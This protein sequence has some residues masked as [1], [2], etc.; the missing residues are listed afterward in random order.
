MSD[1]ISSDAPFTPA[2]LTV[3]GQMVEQIIPASAEY[4]VPSAG[5]EQILAD[6][7]KVLAGDAGT[8]TQVMELMAQLDPELAPGEQFLLLRDAYPDATAALVTV[9]GQC[10]YRDDRV[11]TSLGMAPRAPFPS[12]YE[13]EQGDW[14]LLDPVRE[15][16]EIYRKT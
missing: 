8:L 2:Q 6:I 1:L 3:L 12:G 10:Y 11:M 15:R 5:D 7:A 9:T 13:V 14:S 16:G 4:G